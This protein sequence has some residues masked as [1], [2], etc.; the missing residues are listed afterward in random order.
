MYIYAHHILALCSRT[1]KS[2]CLV[3]F[4]QK[5]EAH[6]AK[7]LFGL[8]GL[9]AAELHGNMTQRAVIYNKL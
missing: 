5:K 4:G 2:N 9:N 6:R 1:I 8:A 7:L 3:F